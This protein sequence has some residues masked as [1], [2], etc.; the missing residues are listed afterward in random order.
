VLQDEVTMISLHWRCEMWFDCV[1]RK[2]SARFP[3]SV[4]APSTFAAAQSFQAWL[5]VFI[6]TI[7]MCVRIYVY[8]CMCVDMYISIYMHVRTD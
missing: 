3:C 8:L 2:R 1:E 7:C 4:T 5:R 6:Y